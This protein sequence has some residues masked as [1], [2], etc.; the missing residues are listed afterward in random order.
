MSERKNMPPNPKSTTPPPRLEEDADWF[1]SS[2]PEGEDPEV[3]AENIEAEMNRM[4]EDDFESDP[5]GPSDSPDWTQE[6][7]YGGERPL[8]P[9]EP[10]AP[11]ED[12][13]HVVD[14]DELSDDEEDDYIE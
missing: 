10:Q 12:Q 7:V 4:D 3:I 14:E 13:L 9:D 1:E 2:G 11:L 5:V 6:A 8:M